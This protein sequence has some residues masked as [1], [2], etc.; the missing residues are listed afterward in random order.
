MF[1]VSKDW[2]PLQKKLKE[3]I[4]KKER[5]NEVKELLYQM[6]SIVHA[7]EVYQRNTINFMDEIW[8]DL[9]DKAFRTMPSIKDDTVAWH[10]WHISRIEDLT[11]NCLI[12]NQSQVL[13]ENWLKRLNIKVTDTGNAMTDDEI[14][15]LSCEINREALFEY[16]NAVGIR[17]KSIID[18]LQPEDM[19]RKV[20]KDGLNRILEEGGVTNHPVSAGLLDFWGKK[21][22]AGIFFMPITRHQIVHL[23]D[24]RRLK[25]VCNRMK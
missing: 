25:G 12:K 3:T 24:C 23:S 11:S 8:Q 7:S 18:A 10:V 4:L 6:H 2:N 1:E 5:F 14:I 13:N 16:R 22:V 20:T 19:K 17:T 9:S 15:S 21:N